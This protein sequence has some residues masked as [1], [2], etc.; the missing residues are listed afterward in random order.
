MKTLISPLAD[1]RA[2]RELDTDPVQQT[3]KEPVMKGPITAKTKLN[4]NVVCGIVMKGVH[5]VTEMEAIADFRWMRKIV[6]RKD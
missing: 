5:A 4:K 6:V 1:W 2:V 3:W